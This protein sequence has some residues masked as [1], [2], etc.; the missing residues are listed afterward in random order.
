MDIDLASK[1]RVRCTAYKTFR[2]NSLNST[3]FFSPKNEQWKLF[4]WQIEKYTRVFLTTC[5]T[6]SSLLHSIV[7]KY[8]SKYFFSFLIVLKTL[9]NYTKTNSNKINFSHYS[10]THNLS[11]KTVCNMPSRNRRHV[12]YRNKTHTIARNFLIWIANYYHKQSHKLSR[13]I[14]AGWHV[15]H[16]TILHVTWIEHHWS[17]KIILWIIWSIYS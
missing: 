16:R 17:L 2:K 10:I 12:L 1:E 4:S 5:S 7:R 9:H 11:K 8:Y 6:I 14:S 15:L 3:F 13:R